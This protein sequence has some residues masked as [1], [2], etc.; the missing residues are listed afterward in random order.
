MDPENDPLTFEL[1]FDGSGGLILLDR[2]TG[3]LSVNHS[4][5]A[6]SSGRSHPLDFENMPSQGHYLLIVRLED[7]AANEATSFVRVS[8]MDANDAPEL[9]VDADIASLLP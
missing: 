8:L 2:T 1:D 7:I 4:A 5:S 6:G 9:T 3:Q